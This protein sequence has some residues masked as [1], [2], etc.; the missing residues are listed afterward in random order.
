MTDDL[1]DHDVPLSAPRRRGLVRI[2]LGVLG[3]LLG[4]AGLLTMATIAA[5][6]A[7]VIAPVSATPVS[8]GGSSDTFEASAAATYYVYVPSAEA[9]AATCSVDGGDGTAW[10]ARRI[11]MPT[12][13]VD[14]EYTQIGALTVETDRT[15]TLSCRGA[16][17][18]AVMTLGMTGTTI[19]FAALLLCAL[20]LL[21]SGLRARVRARRRG[22]YTERL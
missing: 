19:V 20:A 1:L 14:V 18:V 16:T 22:G 11:D 7:T 13:I 21:A 2:V 12:E 3:L 15:V 9:A 6:V 5:F 4:T 17:D 8:V 10:T